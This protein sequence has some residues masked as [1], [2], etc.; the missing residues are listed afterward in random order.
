VRT[1]N[2][3]KEPLFTKSLLR[4]YLTYTYITSSDYDWLIKT[5]EKTE[6]YRINSQ[7]IEQLIEQGAIYETLDSLRIVLENLQNEENHEKLN[8]YKSEVIAQ[9]GRLAA[10]KNDLVQGRC[11]Q[12][13]FNVERNKI[14]E[15]IQ[16]LAKK[17]MDAHILPQVKR[18]RWKDSTENK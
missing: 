9:L 8:P 13:T 7:Y 14:R 1:D 6:F 5:W 16:R 12:E 17:M 4:D 10:A 3:A 15:A 2:P 18:K 11:T